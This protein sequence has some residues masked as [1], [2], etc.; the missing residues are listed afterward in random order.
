MSSALA[1]EEAHLRLFF[2]PD[3]HPENTFEEF[4]Q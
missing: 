3:Y 1:N 2:D 4:I